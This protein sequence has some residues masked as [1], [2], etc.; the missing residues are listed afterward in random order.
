MTITVP[1]GATTPGDATTVCVVD[2]GVGAGEGEGLGEEVPLVV[3]GGTDVGEGGGDGGGG[4]DAGLG[5]GLRV[6]GVDVCR[7]TVTGLLVAVLA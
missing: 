7:V 1:P 6:D 4:G 3:V 5:E 2:G